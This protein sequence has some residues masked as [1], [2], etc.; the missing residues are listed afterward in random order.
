MRVQLGYAYA[1]LGVNVVEVVARLYLLIFYTDVVGLRPSLAGLAVA[2]GLV[3]DAVTDPVMGVVSDRLRHR[4]GGR[5]CFVLVGSFFLA[6]GLVLLFSPPALA[7]QGARFAW[8]LGAYV[9]LNSGLTVMAI[10]HTAMSAE[11][12]EDPHAR[13][14]LFGWRFAFANVGAL[15]AAALP[16]LLSAKPPSD[17]GRGG[18]GGIDA[19]PQFAWITALLIVLGGI[20]VW[21]STRGIAP[22]PLASVPRLQ[23]RAFLS[24]LANPAFR[25]LV[26]GYVVAM[27]GV[28]VNAAVALFYYGRHLELGDQQIQTLLVT[29]LGVWTL[30]LLFWVWISRRVGKLRPL[31]RGATVLGASI[32]VLYL[33]LPPG[34]FVLPLVLG[35]IGIGFLFGSTLL[36]DSLLTDVIDL[37]RLRT[38]EQ[39]AGIYFGFWRFAAKLARAFSLLT[40]GLVLD[41]VGFDPEAAPTEELRWALRLLFGPGVG[42]FFL[43]AGLILLRYRFSDAKQRQ[44]RRLLDRREQRAERSSD[45][46]ARARA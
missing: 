30:S 17:P 13:S 40:T 1:D 3:W 32:C 46:G 19:L 28:G 26:A 36:I 8:L 20:S 44:V 9:F 45:A 39:R 31:A 14:V 16:V 38:G 41:L 21:F 37:D 29:F 42:C 15:L 12:S 34:N 10:P 43:A 11:L 22:P 33:V 5:R 7:T 18:A 27:L 2:L 4:F 23:W 35:G 6:A 24:P 25:P